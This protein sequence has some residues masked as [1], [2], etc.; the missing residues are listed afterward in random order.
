MQ[1]REARL[2]LGVGEGTILQQ[3]GCGLHLVLARRYMERSMPVLGY[4]LEKGVCQLGCCKVGFI[5]TIRRHFQL[6]LAITN[7]SSLDSI[8]EYI[9]SIIF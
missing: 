8:Y 5:V 6:S 9:P 3:G 2:G 4:S 1:R 7:L